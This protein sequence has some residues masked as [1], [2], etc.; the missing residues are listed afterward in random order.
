MTQLHRLITYVI[1]VSSVLAVAWFSIPK[2]A[3]VP[4]GVFLSNGQHYAAISADN[5]TI[6]S[7]T[8]PVRGTDIG[9]MNIEAY[10]ANNSNKTMLAAKHYAAELAAQHGANRVVITLLGVNAHEKI[11]ILRAKALRTKHT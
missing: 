4:R 2:H 10:I 5:V 9:I 6:N 7:Y 8:Q 1:I 11:L 3:F